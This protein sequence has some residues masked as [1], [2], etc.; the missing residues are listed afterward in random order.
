MSARPSGVVATQ[1]TSEIYS[2]DEL[3]ELAPGDITQEVPSAKR[4]TCPVC[5]RW[6]ITTNVELAKGQF[7]QAHCPKCKKERRFTA[8]A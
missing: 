5:G 7:V 6:L 2:H 8:Q 4:W 3:L 1:A